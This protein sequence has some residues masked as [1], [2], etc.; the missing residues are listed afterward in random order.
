MATNRNITSSSCILQTAALK[1]K[2]EKQY[3]ASC[4]CSLLQTNQIFRHKAVA[5]FCV[6]PQ[7]APESTQSEVPV[8]A[9]STVT[10]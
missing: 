6:C 7:G 5:S 8:A 3:A 9:L 2:K 10:E 4:F 1:K